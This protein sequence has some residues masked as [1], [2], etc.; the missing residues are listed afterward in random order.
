MRIY[1][2]RTKSNRKRTKSNRKRTKSNRKHAKSNRKRNK[3]IR[4]HA[5]R[6]HHLYRKRRDILVLPGSKG[7][8]LFSLPIHNK[9]NIIMVNNRMESGNMIPGLRTM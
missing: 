6:S 3:S 4:K 5:K 1:K 9:P 7:I 8:P 2:K